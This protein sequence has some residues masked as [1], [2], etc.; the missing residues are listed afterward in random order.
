M[1]LPDPAQDTYANLATFRR[2]GREVRTPVW[3]AGRGGRFYVFSAG[4]A[5]K[6]KRVRA[7]GRARLAT[8]DLRGNVQSDWLDVTARVLNSEADIAA[9]LAALRKKYGLQ[10]WLTDFIAKLSGRF[11]N[12]AYLEIEVR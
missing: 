9:A 1:A 5:G 4:N 6:V 8:C 11:K 10:M 2:D 3:I 12:R 7:N